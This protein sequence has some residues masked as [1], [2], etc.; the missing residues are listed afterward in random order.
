[1]TSKIE[2]K[3]VKQTNICNKCKKNKTK[4]CNLKDYITFSGAELGSC[5]K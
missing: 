3:L 5:P 2:N 1:M 4:K